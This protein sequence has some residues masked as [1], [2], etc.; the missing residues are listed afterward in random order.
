MKTIQTL[1]DLDLALTSR[2]LALADDEL[3]LAHRDSEWT[4]HAPILEED[5]GLANIAQDEL[6]H[7][8]LWY[9]IYGSLTGSDPDRVVFFREAGDWRNVQLVELPKGDWAFTMLRQYLF[10][11]YEL[12]ALAGLAESQH[13]GVAGAAAKIRREELY[14]HRHSSAWVKRLGLGTEESRRRIQHALDAL[15][16]YTAQLFASG[17]GDRS[18]AAA[19][20]APPPAEVRDAWTAVVRPYLDSSSLRVSAGPGLAPQR[21]QHTPYLAE[22]LS[23]MQKVARLDPEAVW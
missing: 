15:W 12:A 6:G 5:I 7:A 1:T 16:P 11:T 2:V 17:D 23:E 18:L 13:E 10:D 20:Y 4:G 21:D 14:H 19:G 3:I 9:G 8:G 22:L